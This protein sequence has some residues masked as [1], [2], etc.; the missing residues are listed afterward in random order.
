MARTSVNAI[1]SM[2]YSVGLYPFTRKQGS[3]EKGNVWLCDGMRA[4]GATNRMPTVDF[5]QLVQEAREEAKDPARKVSKP[6]PCPSPL[7]PV[8]LTLKCLS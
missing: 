3:V 2:L 7:K 1:Q 8:P 4:N 6:L 5:E